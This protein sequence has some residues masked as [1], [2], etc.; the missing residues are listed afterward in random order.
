MSITRTSE[1]PSTIDGLVLIGVVMPNRRAIPATLEKPTSLPSC[2]ATV[3]IEW[4]RLPK[5]TLL[6]IPLGDILA[7]ALTT[8]SDSTVDFSLLYALP[9][10]WLATYFRFLGVVLSVV[11]P[12]VLQLAR[13]SVSHADLGA[14]ITR[15]VVVPIV[16]GLVAVTV[17]LSRRRV[18]A[19]RALLRRQAEALRHAAAVGRRREDYL[20]AT[21][22]AVGFGIVTFDT[23]GRPGFINATYRKMRLQ[24]DG[25]A[26]GPDFREVYAA[27]GFTP[28]PKA[29]HPALRAAGGDMPETV[30]WVGPPGGVQLA[31]AVSARRTYDLEGRPDGVVMI[32][33]DV[34]S[35]R[36][37][38]RTR[39]N[40]VAVV[41]HELRTP[42]TAIIGYLDL[43]IDSEIADATRSMLSV[44]VT[45]AQR[46]IALTD[47]FRAAAVGVDNAADLERRVTAVGEIVEHSAAAFAAIAEPRN[48][49]VH[50]EDAPRIAAYVDEFRLRQ[51]VDNLLSNAI[52]YCR[53]GGEVR[54]TAGQDEHETTIAVTNDS[55]GLTDEELARIF[56]RFY[57]TEWA[58][59][60][61][62]DGSGLGLAISNDIISRH[63]GRIAAT[64]VPN[65]SVTLTVTLPHSAED[66]A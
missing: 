16:L 27:D 11:L 66:P 49:S 52:K 36:L 3:L 15:I 47:D 61:D 59:R 29:E 46:M 33:R 64:S 63:G 19:Q 20:D 53:P 39:D 17:C 38:I 31:L 21:L 54:I 65:R 45:N 44:A 13:V 60:S 2:A 23:E 48:V 37:A 12:T 40:L 32:S 10:I 41:S 43:A 26:D 51:V 22:E 30:V 50:L 1:L 35:E 6:I 18:D 7:I 5:A 9:V 34:T 8:F 24:V 14:M 25:Q 62:I 55:D 28:L 57:R 4:G 56:D 42:L 58:R